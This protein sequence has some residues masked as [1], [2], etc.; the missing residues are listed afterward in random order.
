MSTKWSSF[1]QPANDDV[2]EN[3][4]EDTLINSR[5]RCTSNRMKESKG[6]EFFNFC[7]RGS[8]L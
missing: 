4:L 5:H 8:S 3:L 7:R 2:E 1:L 6:G